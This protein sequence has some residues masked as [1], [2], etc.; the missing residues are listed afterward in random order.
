MEEGFSVDHTYGAY[1]LNKWFAGPPRKSWLS[2]LKIREKDGI[3]VETYR[4]R[5]CGYLEAYA[6]T[7]PPT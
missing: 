6:G 5:R 3:P 7:R 2:G 1:T 4:C